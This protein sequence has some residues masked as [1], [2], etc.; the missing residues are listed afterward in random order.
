MRGNWKA[1]TNGLQITS[2]ALFSLV[3]SFSVSCNSGLGLDQ[4][5]RTHLPKVT[6]LPGPSRY[7]DRENR[8]LNTI[9]S[10]RRTFQ[11]VETSSWRS[12][13]NSFR[14]SNKEERPWSFPYMTHTCTWQCPP[15]SADGL[16][17]RGEEYVLQTASRKTTQGLREVIPRPAG[18]AGRYQQHLHRGSWCWCEGWCPR[19][20]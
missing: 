7:W 13:R 3:P 12:K 8:S 9:G 1:P 16:G 2:R 11:A 18:C 10:V 20:R 15:P 17:K 4:T 5:Q 19:R 6:P 14:F